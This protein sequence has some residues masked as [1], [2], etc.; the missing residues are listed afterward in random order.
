M[1]FVKTK[2]EFFLIDTKFIEDVEEVIDSL[3]YEIKGEKINILE[4]NTFTRGHYL[5]NIL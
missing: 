2:A 5:K 1:D 4:E 3:Y